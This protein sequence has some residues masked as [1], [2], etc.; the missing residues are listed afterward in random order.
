MT[1]GGC[2]IHGRHPS[3]RAV[4]PG[5]MACPR[6]RRPDDG[7]R[8]HTS[9]ALELAAVCGC[10]CGCALESIFL[11]GDGLAVAG[12]VPSPLASMFYDKK[13]YCA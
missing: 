11:L 10:G 12:P 2:E 7:T 3:R 6:R 13:R 1:V 9:M 5:P 4:A 8:D